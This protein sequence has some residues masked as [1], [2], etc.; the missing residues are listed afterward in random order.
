MLYLKEVVSNSWVFTSDCVGPVKFQKLLENCRNHPAL[1]SYQNGFMVPS[2][3]LQKSIEQ[4]K[5]VTNIYKKLP[6]Y[7]K[8]IW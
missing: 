3:D 2:D 4:F 5:H 6:T 8:K 7:L 1:I